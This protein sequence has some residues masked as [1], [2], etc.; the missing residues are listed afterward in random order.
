MTVP[1]NPDPAFYKWCTIGRHFELI[2]NFGPNS[3]KSDGLSNVCEVCNQKRGKQYHHDVRRGQLYG[4]SGKTYD[5]MYD[6]QK[7][8]C[9]ICGEHSTAL[10]L[11]HDHKTGQRRG[12]LCDSC[13][14]TI[15]MAKDDPELLQSMADYL[16]RFSG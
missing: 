2:E 12:L 13:N 9:A 3:T 15:G 10:N 16:Q 5:D 7:G 11:D 4:V 14:R 6:E 8:C 1:G